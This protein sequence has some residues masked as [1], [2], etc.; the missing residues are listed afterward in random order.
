MAKVQWNPDKAAI[1]AL[2]DDS[3]LVGQAVQRAAG[4]TRD[5]IKENI[6]ADGL[7]DRGTMIN[8][9]T[10][11]KTEQTSRKVVYQV[12]PTVDYAIYQ[13]EGTGP[14]RPR[15]ARALRFTPKGGGRAIYAQSTKGVRGRHFVRRAFEALTVRDFDA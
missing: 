12:G 6:R 2:L 13:E 10:H 11:E 7:I 14:I 3:G 8:S 9:V 1:A 15:R 5:R 4:K